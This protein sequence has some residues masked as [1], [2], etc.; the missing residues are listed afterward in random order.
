MSRGNDIGTQ[1]GFGQKVLN[2]TLLYLGERQQIIKIDNDSPRQLYWSNFVQSATGQINSDL[3][4]VSLWS[5]TIGLNLSTDRYTV[6][7]APPTIVQTLGKNN[8]QIC[9]AVY[10]KVKTLGAVLGLGL[11]FSNHVTYAAQLAV[12]RLRVPVQIKKYAFR[13]RKSADHAEIVSRGRDACRIK[14]SSIMLKSCLNWHEHISPF[15][16][17]VPDNCMT[18]KVLCLGEPRYLGH[19][20]SHREEIRKGVPAKTESFT[21]LKYGLRSGEVSLTLTQPCI[22]TSLTT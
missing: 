4:S 20:L 15:R 5:V 2:W 1:Y 17:K 9:L 12:G 11:T 14:N 16:E 10:D 13:V 18:H 6:L 3:L 19:K 7:V 21:F 8:L 22:M